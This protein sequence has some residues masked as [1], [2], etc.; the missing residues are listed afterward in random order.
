MM[1]KL[2]RSGVTPAECCRLF[3]FLLYS[4]KSSGTRNFFSYLLKSLPV[5]DNWSS[6]E[7]KLYDLNLE[8]ILNR[9]VCIPRITEDDLK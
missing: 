4:Y 6:F 7:V 2:P 5:F 9:Q 1:G 3:W 8:S